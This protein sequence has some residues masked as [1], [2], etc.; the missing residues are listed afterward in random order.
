MNTILTVVKVVTVQMTT[1]LYQS[2]FKTVRITIIT[3]IKWF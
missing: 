1:S 3:F 2:Y